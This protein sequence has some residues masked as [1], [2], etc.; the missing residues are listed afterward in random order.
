MNCCGWKFAYTKDTTKHWNEFGKTFSFP[1]LLNGFHNGLPVRYERR[2]S[3][4]VPRPQGTVVN[5]REKIGS[6]IIINMLCGLQRHGAYCMTMIPATQFNTW[7]LACLANITTPQI[8]VYERRLDIDAIEELVHFQLQL[9]PQLQCLPITTLHHCKEQHHNTPY[10]LHGSK[11]FMPTTGQ[12]TR[13]P[14]WPSRKSV[15][16][17]A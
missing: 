5:V 16:K 10:V 7:T 6:Q 9:R 14:D 17:W 11:T 13:A 12:A 1:L 8:T 15:T 2:S 3:V 4:A